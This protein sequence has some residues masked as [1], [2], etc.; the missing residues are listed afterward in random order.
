[1]FISVD[2]SAHLSMCENYKKWA[3]TS[4]NQVIT[5]LF[6]KSQKIT[7]IFGPTLYFSFFPIVFDKMVQWYIY[8]NLSGIVFLLYVLFYFF[9]LSFQDENIMNSMQLFENVI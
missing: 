7:V 3:I 6:S 8:K 5:A 9:C 1:M 2:E 4:Y